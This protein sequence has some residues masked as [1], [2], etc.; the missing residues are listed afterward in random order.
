M[1][2]HLETRFLECWTGMM[3]PTLEPE[4]KFHP[5]RRWRFDFAHRPS[6]V[7][8]EIEGGIWSGGRHSRGSG[9]SAD[10]EKYNAATELGWA[11]FRLTS[12]MIDKPTLETIA[13]VI[14]AKEAKP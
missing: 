8:I 7:A 1:S 11:V 14:K 2:S 12:K 4:F 5:S 10:C 13:R 3:A 6:K 9:F